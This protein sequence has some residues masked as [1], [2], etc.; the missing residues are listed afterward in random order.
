MLHTGGFVTVVDLGSLPNEGPCVHIFSIRQVLQSVRSSDIFSGLD[1]VKVS[2]DNGSMTISVTNQRGEI[3]L[4]MLK[5]TPNTFI[6]E[7]LSDVYCLPPVIGPS[8]SSCGGLSL[9]TSSHIA[10]LRALNPSTSQ[11]FRMNAVAPESVLER[12]IIKREYAEAYDL[13]KRCNLDPDIVYIKQWRRATDYVMGRSKLGRDAYKAAIVDTRDVVEKTLEKALLSS[14]FTEM[15]RT[16]DVATEDALNALR[17]V[18]SESKF[19]DEITN[20]RCGA[21]H[22]DEGAGRLRFWKHVLNEGCIRLQSDVKY[23][24]INIQRKL[25][26][27]TP[28]SSADLLS[29]I[30]SFV[31]D[32]E[33]GIR[34]AS[35]FYGVADESAGGI[36]LT[37]AV[38]SILSS[39]LRFSEQ[40]LRFHALDFLVASRSISIIPNSQGISVLCVAPR[41]GSN[42]STGAKS[43]LVE[44]FIRD[45]GSQ[46]TLLQLARELAREAYIDE[47]SFLMRIFGASL[48]NHW[49]SILSSIPISVTPDI[50]FSVLPMQTFS[51]SRSFVGLSAD[52]SSNGMSEYPDAAV[53]SSLDIITASGEV[54]ESF[55]VRLL[56]YFDRE[57]ENNGD[58]SEEH[59]DHEKLLQ[60]YINRAML[61][62]AFGLTYVA[63]LWVDCA[64]PRLFYSEDLQKC[65]LSTQF[66][67][68]ATLGEIDLP[69][70]EA[71][72]PSMDFPPHT[73]SRKL[74][75]LFILELRLHLFHFNSLL[76]N[77]YICE[78][79]EFKSWCLTSPRRRILQVIQ[80]HFARV[81]CVAKEGLYSEHEVQ[82]LSLVIH[83]AIR[84]LSEGSIKLYQY[85]S[86]DAFAHMLRPYTISHYDTFAKD[87]SFAEA[88]P[89]ALV[90]SESIKW[91]DLVGKAA[92]GKYEQTVNK[93]YVAEENVYQWKRDFVTSLGALGEEMQIDGGGIVDFNWERFVVHDLIEII[94]EISDQE[95]KFKAL[96]VISEIVD[97]SAPTVSVQSRCLSDYLA[98]ISLVTKTCLTYDDTSNPEAL[99]V[100]WGMVEKTPTSSASMKFKKTDAND[101]SAEREFKHL[102]TLL[103]SVQESLS[104]CDIIRKRGLTP[105]PLSMLLKVGNR[106]S[107]VRKQQKYL[108][109]YLLS[110]RFIADGL[111]DL[112]HVFPVNMSPP[113]K[114]A[115]QVPEAVPDAQTGAHVNKVQSAIYMGLI[116]KVVLKFENKSSKNISNLMNGM[117]GAATSQDENEWTSLG[118]DVL[119]LL[120]LRSTYLSNKDVS[121]VWIGNML[122]QGILHSNQIA[123]FQSAISSIV[124]ARES[125]TFLGSIIA[126]LGVTRGQVQNLVVR[127][128][129][130]IFEAASSCSDPSLAVAYKYLKLFSTDQSK[131]SLTNTED[132]VK[133]QAFADV[134]SVFSLAESHMIPLQMKMADPN[135]VLCHL[136]RECPAVFIAVDSGLHS[137]DSTSARYVPKSAFETSDKDADSEEPVPSEDSLVKAFML[138]SRPCPGQRLVEVF[139]RFFFADVPLS[140]ASRYEFEIEAKCEFIRA[141]KRFSH[142]RLDLSYRVCYSLIEKNLGEVNSL[143]EN[144]SLP[145]QERSRMCSAIS[146]AHVAVCDAVNELKAAAESDRRVIVDERPIEELLNNIANAYVLVSMPDQLHEAIGMFEDILPNASGEISNKIDFAHESMAAILNEALGSGVSADMESIDAVRSAGA[147]N[148]SMDV[149]GS[150]ITIS[151]PD[152]DS[153][154]V[155]GYSFF[156]HISTDLMKKLANASKGGV[157]K[158]SKAPASRIVEIDENLVKQLQSMG[159]SYN[160]AKRAVMATNSTSKANALRW[161]IEHSNDS[162]FDEPVVVSMGNKEASGVSK[163]PVLKLS[164]SEPSMEDA[165]KLKR[166]LEYVNQMSEAYASMVGAKEDP[167]PTEIPEVFS[168]EPP[169]APTPPIVDDDGGDDEED[170]SKSATIIPEAIAVSSSSEEQ[171]LEPDVRVEPVPVNIPND[172]DFSSDFGTASPCGTSGEPVAGEAIEE[173]VVKPPASI[174]AVAIEQC[175]DT[176]AEIPLDINSHVVTAEAVEFD[177]KPPVVAEDALPLPPTLHIQVPSSALEDVSTVEPLDTAAWEDD[178]E[179]ESDSQSETDADED[180]VV[181][182]QDS[183]EARIEEEEVSQADKITPVSSE[184]SVCEPVALADI[185]DV[186][187]SPQQTIADSDVT[188]DAAVNTVAKL[189]VDVNC[190]D[191]SATVDQAEL[192]PLSVAQEVVNVSPTVSNSNSANIKIHLVKTN[193]A[194][195]LQEVLERCMSYLDVQLDAERMSHATIFSWS[196]VDDLLSADMAPLWGD[197][198][199][200]LRDLAASPRREAFESTHDLIKALMATPTLAPVATGILDTLSQLIRQYCDELELIAPP[201]SDQAAINGIVAPNCLHPTPG[202]DSIDWML[203]KLR[204]C[205]YL[206]RAPKQIGDDVYMD[207]DEIIVDEAA[208]DFDIESTAIPVLLTYPQ[209]YLELLSS[210]FALVDPSSFDAIEFLQKCASDVVNSSDLSSEGALQIYNHLL[211]CLI[212]FTL[213]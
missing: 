120:M 142:K 39:R 198:S 48:R 56:H 140:A 182:I 102:L 60:W 124:S 90:D 65:G 4:L 68:S 14:A 191:N 202:F 213:L 27:T 138:R 201:E 118:K 147:C 8:A 204:L 31:G 54:S 101:K 194:E 95:K 24:I 172:I 3:R 55:Y 79:S 35:A 197:Y 139:S 112:V 52:V 36:S 97:V 103:D 73:E 188:S 43:I 129:A 205:A 7:P 17:H 2:S 51:N 175:S 50:L 98:L 189:G 199:S 9:A 41:S 161:A 53:I 176:T 115:S 178:F 109:E 171:K 160:G 44:D 99:N 61:A 86:P 177:I 77:G 20:F 67:R 196:R 78:L 72:F 200:L 207:D 106:T 168:V 154:D 82:A 184:L 131:L 19:I 33:F 91:V 212:G 71:A 167:K 153:A 141:L 12:H 96:L 145:L 208:A 26:S 117:S 130:S 111:D 123:V 75:L 128:T 126:E 107:S 74:A 87:C 150:L 159:F 25:S 166:A 100:L 64:I 186:E 16:W 110:S 173:Q 143:L 125:P 66:S 121:S 210:L 30:E 93:Y 80:S 195:R 42:L 1:I 108:K 15:Q 114:S 122:L 105:P 58:N 119:E 193:D 211:I 149:I 22:G 84:P 146:K 187:F 6:L 76:L 158:S 49:L 164:G 209:L 38:L 104:A 148:Q 181:D 28:L 59:F 32:E 133:L 165:S 94:G 37:D 134:V 113:R 81:G 88:G 69:S 192:L 162:D 40:L 169:R 83:N 45:D 70:F 132:F 127:R 92:L 156:D 203:S 155:D 144:E 135:S 46:G 174:P 89:I 151:R 137:D 13:A 136:L 23:L 180:Q 152:S 185:E 190:N 21:L 183:E 34:P 63:Q 163:E 5:K 10:F 157:M 170:E 179:I 85:L 62:D 11:I 18:A 47:L 206:T 29:S 116:S 57:P